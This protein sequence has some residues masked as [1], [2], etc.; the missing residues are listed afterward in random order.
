VPAE[1]RPF[2]TVSG[3]PSR[4]HREDRFAS[5]RRIRTKYPV[6]PRDVKRIGFDPSNPLEARA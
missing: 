4:L 1:A 5:D 2:R 6:D 3:M